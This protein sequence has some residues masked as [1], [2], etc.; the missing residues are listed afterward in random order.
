MGVSAAGHDVQRTRLGSPSR[1]ARRCAAFALACAAAVCSL[2]VAPVSLA[3]P[4]QPPRRA[5]TEL[6]GQVELARLVDLAAQRL[7][8]NIEYDAGA[9]R[10]AVTLRLGAGVTDEE[11]WALT[12]RVLLSRGFTTVR[13]PGDGVLSVVRIADAPGLARLDDGVLDDPPPPV[14]EAEAGFS[15]V[16]L[17]VT[18]RPA[19]EVAESIRPVLSRQGTASAIG[20]AGL[21]LISDARGRVEQARA[22]IRDLDA[23]IEPAVVEEVAVR[24]LSPEQLAALVGQIAARREQ[25]SGRRTPGEVIASPGGEHVLIVAPGA[26]AEG[27]R[28]LVQQLDRREPVETVTYTPRYF[29]VA[30]V[31]RLIEQS[32]R[33]DAGPAGA[34]ERW[35]LVVDELTGALIVTATPSQHE[36]IAALIERLDSVPTAARRPVRSYTIRNRSVNELLPVLRGLIDAGVLEAHD[37]EGLM[38]PPEERPFQRT[39]RRIDVPGTDPQG[40]HNGD[41]AGSAPIGAPDNPRQQGDR[42]VRQGR[43]APRAGPPPGGRDHGALTLTADEGTN[44][45][46][47]VGEPR[48]LGQLEALIRVLDVRQP[49]VML[50]V[51]LVSLSESQSLDLGVELEKIITSG[52]TLIRLSSLFGLSTVQDGVRAVGDGRGF[53]GVV[54]SPGEFS[55]VLRALETVNRGRSLSLPKVLVNNNQSA[56]FDSVLQQPFASINTS[57]TITTTSFGG[58][59]DAGTTVTIRPQIAE[60]DHLVLEYQVA[61]STFVGEASLEGL[62]PPRQQNRVQSVVTIPDG[63]T[64]V[65]GGLEQT[66]RSDGATQVPLIGRVPLLGELFKTRARSQS[67]SR[68]FVFIRANVMR[69]RG[70]EELKFISARA[71]EEADV[72][73]G[74]PVV[75]PRVIR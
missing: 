4:Q 64:V 50:E 49:Q 62:P 42:A 8:L 43:A 57:P 56:V 63:F 75:R 1:A 11:L 45:L 52:D 66:Q 36:R 22:L 31:G 21:L 27:W 44:T 25:V 17:R 30:E 10:G 68:F 73:D 54:L 9:L 15:S 47:A 55:A 12:N 19:R 16:V 29:G 48:L 58:T 13:M 71:V 53:T 46:I 40:A 74:W 59:Q 60:G 26:H 33:D 41:E 70:L 38:L 28:E 5:L 14:D 39:P 35:R 20:E 67:R 69:D 37:E 3:S 23:P 72:D 61:L 24:N 32:V 18:H 65:L 2:P 51:M 7:G 6:S 34:D